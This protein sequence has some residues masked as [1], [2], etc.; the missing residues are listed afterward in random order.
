MLAVRHGVKKAGQLN[1]TCTCIV[2][3]DVSA[4]VDDRHGERGLG[5][6]VAECT[7]HY[8]FSRR[9]SLRAS[10]FRFES[11]R[12]DLVVLAVLLHGHIIFTNCL[13]REQT[14]EF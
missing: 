12:I 7:V 4:F 8:P 11:Q 2:R 1:G 14:Y 9:R 6:A 10:S 13:S 5:I 3:S